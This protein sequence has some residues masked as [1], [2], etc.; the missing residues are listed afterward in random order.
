[1]QSCGFSQRER[2]SPFM[3]TH[4]FLPAEGLCALRMALALLLELWKLV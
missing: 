3:L 1:V 2:L 4:S